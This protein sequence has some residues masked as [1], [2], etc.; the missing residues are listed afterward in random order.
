MAEGLTIEI[1]RE[2]RDDIT[3][4]K[5]DFNA[6]LDR[7]NERLDL[8]NRRLQRMVRRLGDAARFMKQIAL[9]CARH[10]DVLEKDV[11]DLK[12]RVRRLERRPA[13]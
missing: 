7:T 4:F 5:M 13:R 11:S 3:S 8:T 12:A 10:V 6:R 9:D 1:L 2:I